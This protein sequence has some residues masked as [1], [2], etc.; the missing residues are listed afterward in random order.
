MKM[1]G[2]AIIGGSQGNLRAN[3]GKDVWVYRWGPKAEE[4]GEEYGK[5]YGK[6]FKLV[7]VRE[8]GIEIGVASRRQG[9]ITN[10][11]VGFIPF[12]SAKDGTAIHQIYTVKPEPP[13]FS[14]QFWLPFLYDNQGPDKQIFSNPSAKAYVDGWKKATR[15]LTQEFGSKLQVG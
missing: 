13:F 5:V 15:N 14:K 8:D 12:L 7:G 9:R 2:A 4:H 3:I 10:Y 6:M 11:D 1:D